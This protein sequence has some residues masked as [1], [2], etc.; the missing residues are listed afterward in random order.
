MMDAN[1]LLTIKPSRAMSRSKPSIT[2]LKR[3]SPSW[4][5]PVNASCAPNVSVAG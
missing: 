4:S 2:I 3:S 1:R 5:A